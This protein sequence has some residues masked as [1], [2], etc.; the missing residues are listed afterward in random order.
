MPPTSPMTPLLSR[1]T[2]SVVLP[3]SKGGHCRPDARRSDTPA[4]AAAT[5]SLTTEVIGGPPPIRVG[6]SPSRERPLGAP[7]RREYA[8]KQNAHLGGRWRFPVAK[9]AGACNAASSTT[10]AWRR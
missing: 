7:P 5:A 6:P 3:T 10:R 4:I 8:A 2:L 1:P 9:A